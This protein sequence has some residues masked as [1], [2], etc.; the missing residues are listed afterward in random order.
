MASEFPYVLGIC[1]TCKT[2]HA[3]RFVGYPDRDGKNTAHLPDEEAYVMCEHASELRAHC[4]GSG[5]APERL[6]GQHSAPRT[7]QPGFV[8]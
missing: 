2:V 8:E 6:L 3:T 1:V 7:V 5:L 4:P